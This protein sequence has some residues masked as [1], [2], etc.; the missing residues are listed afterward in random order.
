MVEGT[1]NLEVHI[2]IR[3]ILIA[4]LISKG[5]EVGKGAAACGFEVGEEEATWGSPAFKVGKKEAARADRPGALSS[6]SVIEWMRV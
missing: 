1:R 5:A 3:Q 2:K 6:T 4:H